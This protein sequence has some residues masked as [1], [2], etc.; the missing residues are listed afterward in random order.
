MK[1]EMKKE[2]ELKEFKEVDYAK[3]ELEYLRHLYEELKAMGIN[4]IG[5]LENKIARLQ[6]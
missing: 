6:R 5:D 3:A 4:S 2:V 1:K